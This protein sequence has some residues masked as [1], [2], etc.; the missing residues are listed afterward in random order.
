MT[1]TSKSLA[2][3]SKPPLT[4]S[5]DSHPI[6]TLPSSTDSRSMDLTVPSDTYS[7]LLSTRFHG[8]I[9]GK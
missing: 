5:T 7:K 9:A 4:L 8:L 6:V 1:A 2:L 3:K